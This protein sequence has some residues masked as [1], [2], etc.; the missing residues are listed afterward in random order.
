MTNST[1]LKRSPHKKAKL[2]HQPRVQETN[3]IEENNNVSSLLHGDDY[4]EEIQKEL[5]ELRCQL[6]RER[7]LRINVEEKKRQLELDLAESKLK[8]SDKTQNALATSRQNLDTIVQAIRHLEGD[9]PELIETPT[10]CKAEANANGQSSS[11]N[12]SRRLIV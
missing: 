10:K 11:E 12:A 4:V 9:K 6:E 5:I 8:S 3:Q 2:E 1:E 7:R